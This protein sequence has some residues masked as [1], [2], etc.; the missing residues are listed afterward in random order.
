MKTAH[1]IA[2]ELLA[3]RKSSE[4][5]IATGSVPAFTE[6]SARKHLKAFKPKDAELN[7]MLGVTARFLADLYHDNRPRCLTLLGPSGTGKSMLAR[8]VA[9][10]FQQFMTSRQDKYLSDGI[11]RCAGGFVDWGTALQEMLK[12]GWERLGSYKGDYFV[13]LDDIMA[14]HEKLRELSASKLFEI[15]NTRH[16]KRWTIVTANC[17]LETIQQKL[18]PRIASRLIRDG[19]VVVTLP[20]TTPDYAMR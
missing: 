3:P 2:Q 18:D 6:T 15:L 11:W 5:Q 10:F 14:E 16:G 19:N 1:E 7:S 9:G 8:L 13:A 20:E 17:T 4:L 12:G